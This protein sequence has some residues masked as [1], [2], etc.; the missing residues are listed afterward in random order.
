MRLTKEQ[1]TGVLDRMRP[2]SGGCAHCGS[3]L[4]RIDPELAELPVVGPVVTM[5][6]HGCGHCAFFSAAVLGLTHPGSGSVDSQTEPS[7]EKNAR[8]GTE[9]IEEAWLLGGAPQ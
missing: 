9:P 1:L 8:A 6:C 3:G 2:R 4:L 5:T 7:E